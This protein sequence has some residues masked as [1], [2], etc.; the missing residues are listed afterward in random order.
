ME[1]LILDFI[2]GVNDMNNNFVKN[3]INTCK[4]NNTK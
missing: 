2:L 4:K 1:D 3:M